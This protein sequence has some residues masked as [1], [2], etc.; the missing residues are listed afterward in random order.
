MFNANDSFFLSFFFLPRHFD[1]K[2][3]LTRREKERKKLT[4]SKSRFI[5]NMTYVKRL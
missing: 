1:L 3:A 4:F 5:E 2:T